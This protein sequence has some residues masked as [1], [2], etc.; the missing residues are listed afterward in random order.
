MSVPDVSAMSISRQKNTMG[1]G[2]SC[3]PAKQSASSCCGKHPMSWASTFLGWHVGQVWCTKLR[4]MNFGWNWKKKKTQSLFQV[5]PC[6]FQIQPYMILTFFCIGIGL[7][8]PLDIFRSH[9]FRIWKPRPG[10]N[11]HVL[12]LL[13]GGL[14]PHRVGVF[15]HVFDAVDLLAL[16]TCF[17]WF[18]LQ[19]S[20]KSEKKWH[21]RQFHQTS[22]A[23]ILVPCFVS[24][25][26]RQDQRSK[27]IVC[28]RWACPAQKGIHSR[29]G[30]ETILLRDLAWSWSEKMFTHLF[31]GSGF[32]GLIILSHELLPW[33]RLQNGSIGRFHASMVNQ[34]LTRVDRSSI[35]GVLTKVL[36]HII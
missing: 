31:L 34:F 22:T 32:L 33:N 36:D 30:W 7:I 1:L 19:V 3:S 9:D 13:G 18:Y 16:L 35:F 28:G 5:L 12:W 4:T 15:L 29:R 26:H 8:Q 25:K 23:T 20:K 21:F 24:G 17:W 27:H 14:R 2:S 6:F 10:S 11:R